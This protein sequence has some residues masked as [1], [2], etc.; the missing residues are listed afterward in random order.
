MAT[1]RSMPAVSSIRATRRA[2]IG[3]PG[4]G[5]LFWRGG[6]RAG[7]RLLVLAGVAVPRGDRDDAV[8]RAADRGVDHDEQLH[9][10]VVRADPGSRVPAERLHDE[11][12]GPTDRLVVAAV[13]LTAREGLEGHAAELDAEARSDL[14]RKLGVGAPREQHEALV[15]ADIDVARRPR[16]R[17]HAHRGG[18]VTGPGRRVSRRSRAGPSSL[19]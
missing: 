16:V 10:R 7:A 11:D 12:V 1:T 5:L 15:V 4:G 9:Q 19:R 2:E 18:D 3:S 14:P 13:D 17:E 6:A 8:G